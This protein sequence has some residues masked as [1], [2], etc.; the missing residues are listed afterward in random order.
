VALGFFDH[1]GVLVAW[2]ELRDD[3]P[4]FRTDQMDHAGLLDA[5]YPRRSQVLL[6]QRRASQEI[7]DPNA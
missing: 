7:A 3:F 5:R 1:V 6:K 4:H 2:C